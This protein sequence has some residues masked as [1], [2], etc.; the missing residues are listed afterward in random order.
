[1]ELHEPVPE[2]GGYADVLLPLALPR[3]YTYS[4]PPD[5]AGGIREGVRVE[6]A[7]G[8]KKRY[9]AIVLNA[10]AAQPTGYSPKPILSLIDE[11][12]IALP[13]QLRFWQWLATYYCC[14]L[15]EVMNAALPAHYKLASETSVTLG[16]FFEEGQV[17]LDD[18]EYLV[19]EALSIQQELTLQNIQDILQQQSVL[20]LIRR[21]LDKKLISLKEDLREKYKPKIV[22]CV[23][24]CPAY[25]ED[26][27]QLENAFA[28]LARSD[29]QVETL[30]AYL[31]LSR[32]YGFVR[33]E[34]LYKTAQI[35]TTVLKALIK[36]DILELY[37]REVSRL[38]SYEEATVEAPAL[39]Q[40]QESALHAL[41]DIFKNK[42]TALLYGVTGSGK[43]R[44]Y[45][46]LIREAIRRNEQVLYLLPEIALTTQIIERLKK[47]FGNDVGVYHSRF[48]NN[49]RIEIWQQVLQGKPLVLGA[50]SALF[51][52][53]KRLKWIIVDEEHDPSFKQQEPNPRYHGRDAALY[54][55]SLYGA[56]TILGSATPSLESYYHARRG[57]YGLVNMPE[58]FGGLQMPA[59]QLVD[60]KTEIQ[61]NRLKGHFS[62]PLLEALKDTLARGEQAILFQNR[63]GF[64]PAYRCELCA[65]HAGCIHCDVSMTYHKKSHLLKCHYCNYQTRTPAACPACGSIKLSLQGFGT[66]KVEDEFKGHFPD[67]TIVRMDYD[68]VRSRYAHA[69]IIQDFE[70]GRTQV[71]VGTQMVTKGLDFER[72]GLV[73]VL[74]ADQL[75]HFPDFR[76][77][78]RAFQL[79]TQ[80]SGRAGR[81]YRQGLVLIQAMNIGH[82]VIRE[83]M[84]QD[85]YGFFEREAQERQ[86]FSYP[87]YFR[88]M[89]I[90]L[91]H[92][93]PEVVNQAAEFLYGHLKPQFG[94]KLQGPALP[95]VARIRSFFL[96]DFMLKLE[97][98]HPRLSAAKETVL[99]AA[100]RLNAQ[101]G[102]S[103]V[104]IAIDVDPV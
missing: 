28:R 32:Q 40:Q 96:L 59:L 47:I 38:G 13:V 80:V 84:A 19:A 23:R 57:K 33:R 85:F 55:A 67:T 70:E 46:E 42:D 50:R 30:M 95:P 48:N 75:L 54:L 90:T 81:K 2:G 17:G 20:P 61:Q 1:M 31:Q 73:G 53:F 39:S 103:G 65:W 37:E 82:P 88:I 100:E 98:D 35:D 76:A 101:S 43:T 62:Q 14:T 92:T 22:V 45:I 25:A 58:R 77:S 26:P 97:R 72:V 3:T 94:T 86:Q 21:M 78:E 52:P 91:K 15:G 49:E 29:R 18:K 24:L 87:P 34:D 44:V 8:K 89:R 64:A 27:R 7:F 71:L 79:M 99:Q 12:P 63:R 10:N 74:S 83:V 93:K 69:Q 56:K 51:L 16:P 4:V 36:K 11:Q 60:L 6:V 104:R 41:R 9:S 102:M 5:L 68:T 66:E